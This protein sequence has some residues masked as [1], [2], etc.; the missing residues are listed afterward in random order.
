MAPRCFTLY[1]LALFA[2]VFS[3]FWHPETIL[4]NIKDIDNE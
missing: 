2:A 4:S 1:L 3:K